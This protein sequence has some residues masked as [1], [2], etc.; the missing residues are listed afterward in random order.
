MKVPRRPTA[1]CRR[2]CSVIGILS[3]ASVLGCTTLPSPSVSLPAA[4]GISC[5]PYGY[6][7]APIA[8][9]F[10]R[11][12]VTASDAEQT[13]I[14]LFHAC[15]GEPPAISDL[16]F[17]SRDATGMRG[18]PNAGRPVWLVQIDA[19]IA[20][21]SAQGGGSYGSHWLVEVNQATGLPTLVA[22]G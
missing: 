6:T 13:A 10:P 19:T 7:P 4:I 18:G 14:A 22:Y 11:G 21:P 2:T 17:S 12:P 5:Q 8:F 15:G 1:R 16:T 3:L 20:I 9:S